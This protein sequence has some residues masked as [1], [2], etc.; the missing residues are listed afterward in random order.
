MRDDRPMSLDPDGAT[1]PLGATHTP[2]RLAVTDAI[3]EHIVDGTYPPGSRLYEESLATELGVSRNPVRE[4]FQVL[5][6]EGFV[7]LE[8]RRGAR[9]ASIDATRAAEIF[10]VRAGLE[11]MVAELAARK[12][13]DETVARLRCI[14]SEG[15]QVADAGHLQGLP[16]LNT[17]FHEH[18]ADIADNSLLTSMLGQ[19]SGIIRWIYAERLEA[20]VLGSW[21]EHTLIADA[22]AAGDP[23]E[24]R[25]L[26]TAHVHSARD[27]YFAGS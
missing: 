19:L 16:R 7:I 1:P 22:V 11:G 10:E 13:T 9:V 2:L 25:R 24:A 18:L 20:R 8:P 27:A 14:V 12:R 5:A 23:V 3:R 6:G 17:R 21:H 26:A 15:Q 4:A